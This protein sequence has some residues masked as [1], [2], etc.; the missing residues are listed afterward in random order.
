MLTDC[1][2]RSVLRMSCL[3]GYERERWLCMLSAQLLLV[4]FDPGYDLSSENLQLS[5]NEPLHY[6]KPYSPG[7]Y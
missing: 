4:V 3:I 1:I 5:R 2:I 7:N 6:T